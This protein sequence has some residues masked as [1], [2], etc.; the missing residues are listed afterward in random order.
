MGS[1]QHTMVHSQPSTASGC[2][3]SPGPWTWLPRQSRLCRAAPRAGRRGAGAAGNL[4]GSSGAA[5]GLTPR[6]TDGPTNGHK[7]GALTAPLCRVWR[8]GCACTC[9]WLCRRAAA[10]G[11]SLRKGPV[12]LRSRPSAPARREGE[13]RSPRPGDSDVA[14][15]LR[16][17]NCPG[18]A[19]GQEWLKAPGCGLPRGRGRDLRSSPSL[20]PHPPSPS[21]RKGILRGMG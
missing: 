9:L 5:D 15:L 6:L 7:G 8:S 18:R 2:P 16:S 17:L 12:S 10:T 20:L 19:L 1:A 13:P 3:R 11:L 21:A 4:G 14:P